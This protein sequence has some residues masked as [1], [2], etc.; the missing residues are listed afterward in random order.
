MTLPAPLD[1][2][3]ARFEHAIRTRLAE[4][5]LPKSEQDIFYEFCYCTCTPQSK[6]QHALAVVEL[7][8]E[9]AFYHQPFDPTPILAQR[10]HYIR[11][12][13]TKAQRLLLLR[14]Q[15]GEI[16]H[17]FEREREPYALREW[18]VANVRGF[19]YKEA[20]HVLRNL[21]YTELAIIDRHILRNL[22]RFGVISKQTPPRNAAEYRA[23]ERAFQN[24][25]DRCG[26]SLQT[27]DLLLWAVETG[28]VLK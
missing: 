23:V 4:F 2:E 6:A 25:A 24:F 11:F 10:E 17:A 18:I 7:L 3:Y 19:G 13:R 5:A 8:R 9:R 14:E 16:L 26:V 1:R 21:G 22:A 28:A 15:F 12:H 20:S 27:L